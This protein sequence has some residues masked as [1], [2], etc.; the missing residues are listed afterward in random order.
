MISNLKKSFMNAS[1]AVGLS[2]LAACGPIPTE[3]QPLE[4][5]SRRL[6]QGEIDMVQE[7]FGDEINYQRIFIKR[8]TTGVDRSKTIAG[9]IIMTDQ[10]YADDYSQIDDAQR[11][12]VFFHEMTHILQGQTGV[13]FMDEGIH[14]FLKHGFNKHAPYKYNYE[15]LS[16]FEEL[17]TEQQGMI[18]QNYIR[19]SLALNEENTDTNCNQIEI[20]RNALKQTFPDI[21][22]MPEMCN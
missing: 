3:D 15:D 7:V 1:A 20:H 8:M 21:R 4:S 19:W 22:P 16:H 6:T 2:V 14:N 12:S 10:R 18:V 17:G 11:I 9:R 5:N 13:N